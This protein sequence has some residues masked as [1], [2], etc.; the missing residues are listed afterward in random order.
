MSEATT[1]PSAIESAVTL[2][3][4]ITFIYLRFTAI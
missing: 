3:N 4:G 1:V 2:F